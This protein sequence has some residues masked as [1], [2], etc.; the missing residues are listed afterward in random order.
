MPLYEYRCPNCDC[1]DDLRHEAN[2]AIFVSCLICQGRC[3]RH[4]GPDSVPH[5]QEDRLRFFRLSHAGP[6]D[7]HSYALGQDMPDSR[8]ELKR[9]E[10][11]KGIEFVSRRDMPEQWK[12][13]AAHTKHVRE[14]GE[15]QA[16]DALNPR[17]TKLE[18]G[19]IMRKVAEKG[20]RFGA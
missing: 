17:Q 10:K 16:S 9:L 3:E 7:R 5:F 4:F 14:G 11:A 12:A 13:L 15:V 6:S 19:S 1:I 2:A 18:P 8:S 20:I